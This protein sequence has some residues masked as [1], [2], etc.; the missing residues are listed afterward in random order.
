ME[1]AIN[2]LWKF[3]IFKTLLFNFSVYI[4]I[5]IQ[6]LWIQIFAKFGSDF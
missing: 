6:F 3:R 1:Y 5:W 4:F 2:V